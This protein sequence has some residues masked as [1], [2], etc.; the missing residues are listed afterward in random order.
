MIAQNK[1]TREFVATV[2]IVKEGKVLLTFNKNIK[3]FIPV[4]GHVEKDETPCESA[5]REA[6]EESGFDVNL[7]DLGKLNNKNL[8][9][10]FDIQLDVIK[11]NHHHI[12]LSY[13]GIVKG[14]KLLEKSD[15]GTALKWFSQEELINLK[16]IMDNTREKAIKSIEIVKGN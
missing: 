14:G 5:L 2:Y 9:Q 12:N 15:E 10:N 16:D 7:I 3:K 11:S 13:I 4:G 8:P 1:P 6:K